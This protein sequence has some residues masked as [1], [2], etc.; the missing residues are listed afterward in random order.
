MA[1]AETF[2]RTEN[3]DGVAIVSYCRLDKHNAW[4]LGMYR[5]IEAAIERANADDGIGAIVLRS[6]GPVFCA[7]ADQR[8]G[9]IWD[10]KSGRKTHMAFVAMDGATGWHDLMIRSKPVIAAVAGKAIG[11]GVTHILSADIILASDQALFDFAF[12][13]LGVMPEMGS[14]ALLGAMVGTLRAN[15][16]ILSARAIDGRTAQEIGLASRLC[17]HDRIDADALEIAAHIAAFDRSAV[18]RSKA[19]L[20]QNRVRTSMTDALAVERETFRT[21][22]KERGGV[23]SSRD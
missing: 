6:D 9:L 23:R 21:F 2:V 16:I 17:D 4:N 12:L 13:R 18:K 20:W 3:S 7:G 10:E 19:M 5:Q 1:M 15:D 22:F 14:T 11:I 8:E